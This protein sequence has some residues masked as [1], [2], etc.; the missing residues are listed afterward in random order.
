MV[1]L[2]LAEMELLFPVKRSVCPLSP[3]RINTINWGSVD[4]LEKLERHLL[5]GTC[6]FQ[7]PALKDLVL[8]EKSRGST[9]LLAAIDRKEFEAVRHIVERWGADV[10]QFGVY[11]PAEQI[12]FGVSPFIMAAFR[13]SESILRYLVAKKADVSALT[14]NCSAD[15][16]NGLT[17][18]Q[19]AIYFSCFYCPAGKCNHLPG[20]IRF[21]VEK[22]ADV[23]SVFPD[24]TPMWKNARIDGHSTCLLIQLG[25][26]LEQRCPQT[27]KT[28]LHYWGASEGDECSLDVVQL[29]L[30]KGLRMDA[31]DHDGLTPLLGAALANCEGA[32]GR[33]VLQYLINHE[34][35]ERREKVDAM[36]LAGSQL[37]AYSDGRDLMK[38]LMYWKLA[39]EHREVHTSENGRQPTV[40]PLKKTNDLPTFSQSEFTSVAQ[41]QQMAK[42]WPGARVQSFLVRQ[43]ILSQ[44]SARI[45]VKYQWHMI[46]F[47]N[48]SYLMRLEKD[49]LLEMYCIMLIH[50]LNMADE[51]RSSMI[52][53]TLV[54]WI[55][56]GL[57]ALKSYWPNSPF[58]KKE[59]VEKILQLITESHQRR[60]LQ[61]H[62]VHLRNVSTPLSNIEAICQHISSLAMD[63]SSDA[64]KSSSETR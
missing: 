63:N 11:N 16:H 28:A 15:E 24:G 29:L 23:S 48:K 38:G 40:E 47:L 62:Q 26:N 14:R 18:L 64:I 35:V 22:G 3:E 53:T 9:P 27:G 57:A 50:Q 44:I 7:H 42:N 43:R 51:V 46:E 25:M 21:L 49:S 61:D 8:T 55:I 59:N 13:K 36:E 33:P 56:E 58:L 6:A 34:T 60:L 39:L 41:L 12:S 19:A 10:N 17:A 31:V 5:K 1:S 30:Q 32:T 52:I 54:C 37:L 45:A 2:S 20:V 4:A